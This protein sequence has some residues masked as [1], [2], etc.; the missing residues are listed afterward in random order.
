M[1]KKLIENYRLHV[2]DIAIDRVKI[3]SIECIQACSMKDP[4]YILICTPDGNVVSSNMKP[5]D[6]EYALRKIMDNKEFL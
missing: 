3:K 2:G 5:N 1:H 4:T 6:I